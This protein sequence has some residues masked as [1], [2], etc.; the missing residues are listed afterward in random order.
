MSRLRSQDGATLILIVGVVAALAILAASMVALTV[1]VQHN[2]ATHRTQSKA[3][4]VAEA[5]LDAGQSA[6]WVK[7][8]AP[9]DGQANGPAPNPLPS[10]TPSV[11]Q[12]QFAAEEFP[13]PTSGPFIDVKFYDDDGQFKDAQGNSR[14][15]GILRDIPYDQNN[16]GYMWIESQGATGSRATKVMGLVTKVT[17]DLKVRPGV[18]LYTDGVLTTKGTGNQPVIGVDNIGVT[19]EAYA[20]GGWDSSGQADMQGVTFNPAYDPPVGLEDVFPTATLG[21]LIE[22]AWGA[23]KYFKTQADV[24]DS[25]W[26]TEPRLIVIE[27]GGVDCKDIPDTDAF[28]VW[29]D[30][31]PGNGDPGILIVLS[32]DM[33]QTGQKKTIW[34]IVY[35]VNGVLLRGN[36]EIHGMIIAEGSADLRGTRAVNYNANVIANLNRPYLLSVKLVSNTWRE[37]QPQ[38]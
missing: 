1:N 14:T 2:T 35:L 38:P 26:S 24:P 22:A 18:A 16:N 15:P 33:N 13:S 9:T 19:A 31:Q 8:P 10:V 4:N 17:R 5:G 6:L 20:Q 21:T 28:G 7:W 3:F 36:A 34:G 23:E 27:S 12:S 29:G 25:A 37:L 32:G 11:I 30:G